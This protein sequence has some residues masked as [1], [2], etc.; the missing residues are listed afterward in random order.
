MSDSVGHYVIPPGIIDIAVTQY[1]AA[2]QTTAR[3]REDPVDLEAGI[4]IH[5][6]GDRTAL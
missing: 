3:L 4:F 1:V 2:R 6:E 5:W